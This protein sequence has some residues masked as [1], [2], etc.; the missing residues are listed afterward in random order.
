MNPRVAAAGAAVFLILLVVAFS[1]GR[2]DRENPRVNV[3]GAPSYCGTKATERLPECGW[4]EAKEKVP[5]GNPGAAPEPSFPPARLD[6]M[7]ELVRIHGYSCKT[8][9]D[10]RNM[11]TSSS[12]FVLHCY[13]DRPNSEYRFDIEDRGGRFVVSPH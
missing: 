3:A 8:P 5:A 2:S 11:L 12:G 7:A 4:T 13:G 1:G 10:A 6:A 9:I